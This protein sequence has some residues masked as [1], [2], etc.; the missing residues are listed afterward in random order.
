MKE[1]LSG[2]AYHVSLNVFII[3]A[4]VAL[5]IAWLYS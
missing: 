1:S 2:F 3:I 4:S 5:D